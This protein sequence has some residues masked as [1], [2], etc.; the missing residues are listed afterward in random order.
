MEKINDN[1]LK[2]DSIKNVCILAGHESFIN[3]NGLIEYLRRINLK[4][5]LPFDITI[6]GLGKNSA[7]IIA[8]INGFT[9]VETRYNNSQDSVDI[10]KSTPFSNLHS[11]VRCYGSNDF[12]EGRA[13]LELT[14][15]DVIF[16]GES[17]RPDLFQ[18]PVIQSFQNVTLCKVSDFIDS[19]ENI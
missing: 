2:S 3:V 4:R 12:R 8:R 5:V 15:P 9:Y 7:Y 6:N 16:V 17:K 11:E 13:V 1:M 19:L 18:N 10:I 14:K